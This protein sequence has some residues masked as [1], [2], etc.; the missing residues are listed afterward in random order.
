MFL[1]CWRGV[2]L[3]NR[4]RLVHAGRRSLVH[5]LSQHSGEC[6]PLLAASAK[7]RLRVLL[8]C[9][10]NQ[11]TSAFR[12]IRAASRL[13]LLTILLAAG[14]GGELTRHHCLQFKQLLVDV[15]QLVRRAHLSHL[16]HHILGHINQVLLRCN[17]AR[18]LFG[19][20]F[21]DLL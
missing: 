14:R 1:D 6:H 10:V 7:D 17:L 9:R 13:I 12:L 8:A 3:T 21:L 16:M 18:F 20:F 2:G 4:R 11:G 15:L 5:R 19:L